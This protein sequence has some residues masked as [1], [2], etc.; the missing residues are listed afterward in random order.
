MESHRESVRPKQAAEMLGVGSATIWRWIKERPDFPQPRRLSARCT[1]FDSR[2][3]LAW[4][5]AQG[6]KV[7]K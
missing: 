4:R 6:V 2:E 7:V 3:L 5:D 1:V